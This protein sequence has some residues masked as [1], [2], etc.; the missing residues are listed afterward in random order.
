MFVQ[1]VVSSLSDFGMLTKFVVG[2]QYSWSVLQCEPG[3][4]CCRAA[5]DNENCCGNNASM[6]ST[7][8]IGN[9]LVPGS[10]SAINTTFNFTT[11]APAATD[12]SSSANTTCSSNSASAFDSALCPADNSATVG[13]AVGGVLGAALIGALVALA[14][15]LRSRKQYRSDLAGTKSALT[16]TETQ[17]AEEKAN[18][19]KQLEDQQRHFQSIPPTY[20]MMS[21][22]GGYASPVT[23]VANSNSGTYNSAQ[24]T[25]PS[26]LPH[27]HSHGYSELGA[28]N[29]HSRVE[30]TTEVPKQG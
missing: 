8:H 2:N 27:N 13:G 22:N 20:N 25:P 16:T 4:F 26:E 7:S 11:E 14:F 23:H 15:A 29:D 21:P 5:S 28:E 6:I 12:S 19:H 1:Y 17:A 3:K 9:L 30:L 18:F 24:S 10:T